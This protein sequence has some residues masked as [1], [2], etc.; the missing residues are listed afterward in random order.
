MLAEVTAES[1][2]FF[3]IRS[4]DSTDMWA[5]LKVV[6]VVVVAFLVLFI[7]VDFFSR[8]KDG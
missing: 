7:I 4:I 6:G 8:N 1:S 5:V 2:D 3:N